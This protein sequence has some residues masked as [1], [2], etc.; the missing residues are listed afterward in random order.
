MFLNKFK[1]WLQDNNE[2][3]N[4]ILELPI[5]GLLPLV[6]YYK[7]ELKAGGKRTPVLVVAIYNVEQLAHS[8]AEHLQGYSNDCPDCT[9]ERTN[10]SED[11]H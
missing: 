6:E 7:S 8:I 3:D 9:E 5:D 10:A 2:G 11:K 4:S 1:K